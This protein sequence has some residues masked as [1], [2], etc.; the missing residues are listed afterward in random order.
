VART[1]RLVSNNPPAQIVER[2]NFFSIL[3]CIEKSKQ[4]K[5]I[6]EKEKENNTHTHIRGVWSEAK[7][8]EK[9][10]AAEKHNSEEKRN[11]IRP[12]QKKTEKKEKQKQ[13]R[14]ETRKIEHVGAA[15]WLEKTTG[16]PRV[17]SDSLLSPKGG[18]SKRK[19]NKTHH[20]TIG[21][22]WSEN[23][24]ENEQKLCRSSLIIQEN[25]QIVGKPKESTQK[26]HTTTDNQVGGVWNKKRAATKHKAA[27][28]EKIR[29]F[30]E[31]E[32]E[33]T[34]KTEK[35]EKNSQNKK[36]TEETKLVG[37][38][39]RPG[40]TTGGPHNT[41]GAQDGDNPTTGAT[42]EQHTAKNSLL[43]PKGGRSRKGE[44]KQEQQHKELC[45]PHTHN[46]PSP[47]PHCS[48]KVWK[49]PFAEIFFLPFQKDRNF[50]QDK[51]QNE[52]QEKTQTEKQEKT[53]TDRNTETKQTHFSSH[54]PP[55]FRSFYS[56]ERETERGEK[57]RERAMKQQ[58]EKTQG[59]TQT[60][61]QDTT[62]TE[63]NIET[64]LIR[65]SP[66]SY[67]SSRLS[68]SKEEETEKEEEVERAVKQQEEK[69]T[70]NT[71]EKRKNT[72]AGVADGPETKTG[73]THVNDTTTNAAQKQHNAA[74]A[75]HG[76]DSLLSPK[77]GRSRK[78][79]QTKEQKHKG[80]CCKQ[81]HH[82]SSPSPHRFSK[83]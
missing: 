28:K 71:K 67:L 10:K 69:Q 60:E 27:Q 70:Q 14:V 68:S 8:A 66:H 33:Q 81:T 17:N 6:Q 57:E 37:V 13:N 2:R 1:H 45:C 11:E 80:V 43:S 24:N 21:G 54:S 30:N 18:R 41:T 22:V 48:S 59:P 31:K 29:P 36:E 46:Q 19:H 63:A 51:T 74:A 62:H 42:H 23:K 38:D 83:L 79:E 55:S 61:K 4:E 77:G 34:K 32:K 50:L 47:S 39:G 16:A 78:G 73:A 75:A 3:S 64:Q 5:E 72:N 49:E 52:K 26:A 12:Y 44:Q 15:N 53:Q 65:L 56:N 7:A 82:P 25:Q 9:Q 76:V 20:T 58:Q 35:K 40:A